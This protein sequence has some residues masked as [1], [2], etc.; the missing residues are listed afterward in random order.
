MVQ[1]LSQ[2]PTLASLAF[3]FATPH[4]TCPQLSEPVHSDDVFLAGRS[5]HAKHLR[6]RTTA[7]ELEKLVFATDHSGWK[8]KSECEVDVELLWTKE[9]GASVYSSPV[10]TDLFSDGKLD[11]VFSTF[12]RYLDALE[13]R[14]GHNLPGWP[15]TLEHAHFHSSPLLW[16]VD[17]DGADDLLFTTFNGQIIVMHEDGTPLHGHTH[18]LPPLRVRKD[19]YVG[20]DERKLDANENATPRPPPPPGDPGNGHEHGHPTPSPIPLPPPMPPVPPLPSA[21]PPQKRPA[22]PSTPDNSSLP[23]APLSAATAPS[24]P[25][26]EPLPTPP[27]VQPTE[28]SPQASAPQGGGRR[29]LNQ[30]T[31]HQSRSG[32]GSPPS[33]E[34][35]T[36]NI[37]RSTL[38]WASGKTGGERAI[39]SRQVIKLTGISV[40]AHIIGY[41]Y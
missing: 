2:L 12:V 31:H 8:E 38:G 39:P 15:F 14:D 1:R 11:I 34:G 28:L 21:A 33:N 27:A 6:E 26:A 22:P 41:Y 17:G 36:S 4:I 24:M 35:P 9:M 16:D 18:S 13:G 20:L 23:Q 32:L 3:L 7:E 30:G 5:A 40:H 37:T 25:R 29:R 19:W 10:I